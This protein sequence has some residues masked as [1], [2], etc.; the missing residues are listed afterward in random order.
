MLAVGASTRDD[1]RSSFSNYGS[2]LDL[3]APGEGIYSTLYAA[4]ATHSYGYY[5][6]TGNGT[7]FA[8]PLVSGVAALVRGLRPDLGQ[9]AVYE[10]IR[11]TADDVG[12]PGFDP[13]TGWGRLNAYRAVAEAIPGLRLSLAAD[14][15]SVAVGGTSRVRV[16]ITSPAGA[17]AGLG[18][19]VAL[20]GSLGSITPTLVDG[21]WHGP[22]DGPVCGGEHAGHGGNHRDVRR[23]ERHAAADDHLGHAGR[24][25]AVGFAGATIPS[26]G[27]QAVITATVRDE[28]GSAVLDGTEVA[29]TTTMGR[30]GS[31]HGH[32]PGGAGRH[33]PHVR[34][35]GRHCHRGGIDRQPHRDDPGHHP[36]RGGT[37][38]HCAGRR[39][40]RIRAWAVRPGS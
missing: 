23:A 26:G 15:P 3:L 18:A 7:S 11:R 13:Q 36:G 27:A 31:G 16:Q 38:S 2:R 10:L 32:H 39:S 8:A 22:G 4:G 9:D 21:G 34:R 25:G 30:R 40:V 37:L 14:P 28:G 1:A 20:T 35:A 33:P 12:A 6:S 24:A 5:G 29:F 19:R 17:A